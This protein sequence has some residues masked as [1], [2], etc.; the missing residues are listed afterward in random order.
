MTDLAVIKNAILPIL[1]M[2]SYSDDDDH[3]INDD[4][5]IVKENCNEKQFISSICLLGQYA[6]IV[7][8]D[9]ILILNKS[10]L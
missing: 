8:I 3:E 9:K 4:V 1:Y 2:T 7:Q 5:K 6:D 10:L